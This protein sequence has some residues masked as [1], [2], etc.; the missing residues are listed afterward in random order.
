MQIEK[1][2]LKEVS[3][4]EPL[5]KKTINGIEDGLEFLDN[6]ISIGDSGRP[7]ILAID[8]NKALTII[9]LKSDSADMSAIVQIIGYY[10]WFVANIALFS[11]S[12][13]NINLDQSIRLMIVA[14]DFLQETVRLTKYLDLEI[15]LVRYAAIKNIE[16]NDIGIIYEDVDISPEKGPEVLFRSIEDIEKYFSN[17]VLLEEFKKVTSELERLGIE[18]TPYQGGRNHWLECKYKNEYIGYLQ[19]RRKYFNCQKYNKDERWPSIRLETYD[20]WEKQCKEYF[21]ACVEKK[22]KQDQ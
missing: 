21:L 8:R 10:E 16:T 19:S 14:P 13:D 22:N 20:E 11:R 17:E 7:D 1:A 2:K 3:E 12:F 5:V 15:S 4:L 6:Q 18:I 9:E